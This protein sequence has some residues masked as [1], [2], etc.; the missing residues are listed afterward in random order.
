MALSPAQRTVVANGRHLGTFKATEKFVM[1]DFGLLEKYVHS[2]FGEKLT[3]VLVG[4]GE[5]RLS[6]SHY[7]F[8]Y[9]DNQSKSFK[10]L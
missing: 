2:T 10:A 7:L 9:K 1:E 8:I 3:E 6:V 4:E 5:T